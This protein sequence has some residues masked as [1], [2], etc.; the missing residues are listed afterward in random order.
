MGVTLTSN[1]AA[2]YVPIQSYT[3]SGSQ[4]NI[5]FTSI[6]QTFTDLILIINGFQSGGPNQGYLQVGNGTID[7]GSNYSDTFMYG[8]G[9][10]ANSGRTT[11]QSAMLA[12]YTGAAGISGDGNVSIAHFM[13]YSNTTTYKTVLHRS[14]KGTNGTDAIVSLWRSTSAINTIKFYQSAG[15]LTAGTTATLYGILG[16]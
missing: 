16:A 6:P 3:L 4:S 2:T 10:S 1:S 13:N 14:G 7:T 12:D 8:N 9:S 11:G 15:S 5:T